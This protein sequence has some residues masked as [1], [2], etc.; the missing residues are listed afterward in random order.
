MLFQVYLSLATTY[1]RMHHFHLA[2]TACRDA[3]RLRKV[4]LAYFR[5]S[6]AITYD[7]SSSE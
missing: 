3:I 7:L 5:L 1:M 6:Q 2:Q 4:S